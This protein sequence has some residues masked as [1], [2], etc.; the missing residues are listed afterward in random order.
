MAR[1]RHIPMRQCVVCRRPAAQGTL[2]R[3]VRREDGS[4]ALDARGKARGRGAYLCREAGCLADAKKWQKLAR[5][6]SVTISPA[7]A[8]ELDAL[9]GQLET[10]EN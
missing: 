7:Q 1:E 3:F 4:V 8:E 10:I 6:L 5:S 9:L 2:I